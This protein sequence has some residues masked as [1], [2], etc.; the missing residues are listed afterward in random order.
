MIDR[1]S[2]KQ[3]GWADELIEAATHVAGA[4]P[5]PVAGLPG[6]CTVD[7]GIGAAATADEVDLSKGPPVALAEPVLG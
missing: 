7:L 3:L 4:L 2:L 5:Q 1:D 6:A